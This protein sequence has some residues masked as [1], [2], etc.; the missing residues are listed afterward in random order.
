MKNKYRKIKLEKLLRDVEEWGGTPV[1]SD[2]LEEMK[3]EIKAIA[4]KLECEANEAG[5]QFCQRLEELFE[6]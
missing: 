4:Y 2:N 6:D 3:V 1:N 5:Y